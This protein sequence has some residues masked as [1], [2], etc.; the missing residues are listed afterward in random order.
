MCAFHSVC[1]RV[2]ASSHA[3]ESLKQKPAKQNGQT[4][5]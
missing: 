4:T 5:R 3:M 1:P 2:D